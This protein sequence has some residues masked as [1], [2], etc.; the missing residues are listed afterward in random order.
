MSAR[1]SLKPAPMVYRPIQTIPSLRTHLQWA[2]SGELSVVPPYLCAMY[3]IRDPTSA[4][5]AVI[6][7]VVMEEMLHIMQVANLLNA[8]GGKPSLAKS[9]IPTYPG[10]ALHNA[11]GGPFIQLKPF[12]PD[13]ARSVF[14]ALEQPDPAPSMPVPGTT[15]A[16]V[17]QFYRAIELGFEVCAAKFPGK[18][19]TSP[20]RQLTD[21]YFGPG[22]GQLIKVTDIPSAKLAIREIR[23]QG[24]GADSPRHPHEDPEPFGGYEHY[25]PRRDGTYGPILGVGWEMSHYRKFQDLATGRTPSPAT[26]PMQ[27][28][29]SVQGFS[30]TTRELAILF[31]TV[32]TWLLRALELLFGTAREEWFFAI[33][34]P[35]MRFALRPLAILL[36]QTPLQSAADPSSGPNAGPPFRF[37]PMPHAKIVKLARNLAASPPTDFGRDYTQ[38]W[39]QTFDGVSKTLQDAL[40]EE[41]PLLAVT[42][43]STP[44]ISAGGSSSAEASR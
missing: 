42:G 9:A 8:I 14:M 43:S 7:S 2:L 22:G 25:G 10:F 15:F 35:M 31:N 12:S 30:G 34:F 23:E 11:V 44:A 20:G 19:F 24:E 41:T 28:N 3:S 5:Y 4:A 29:P 18:L 26:Y 21:T 37:S 17:G 1:P 27:P 32:Y 36:M 39:R 40:S 33:A 38:S 6:R 16:T 13:L